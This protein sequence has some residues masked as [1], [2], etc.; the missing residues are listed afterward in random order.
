MYNK[1]KIIYTNHFKLV[2]V[3]N[4]GLSLFFLHL[5]YLKGFG[6]VGLY[7]I[8]TAFKLMGYVVTLL[9][10]KLL[11]DRRKFYYYNLGLG[12]RKVLGIFFAIDFVL[13]AVLLMFCWLCTSFV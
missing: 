7:N 13:C 1:L 6:K 2:F 5:F 8:L 3:L 4:L 11:F 10:E 9:T 12:Y